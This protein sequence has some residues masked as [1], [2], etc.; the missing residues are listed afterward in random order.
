MAQPRTISF[1][2]LDGEQVEETYYFQIDMDDAVEMELVRTHGTQ[3]E[4]HLTTVFREG[5]I[6]EIVRTM[7]EMLFAGVGLREGNLLVKDEKVK[8]QFKYG[9]AFKQL[10][11]ELMEEDNAGADFFVSM[12]PVQIQKQLKDELSKTYSKEELLAM[13]DEEFDRVAGTDT[14][15]MPVEHMQIAFLRRTG[16]STEAA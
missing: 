13:S 15:K 7:K 5:N 12:M 6:P 2:N 11:A 3:I 1:L 9:G 16:G 4:N 10:F 14:K 8:R